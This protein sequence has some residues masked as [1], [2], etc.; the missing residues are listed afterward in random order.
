MIKA[1][2]DLEQSKILK[3]I[4][5]PESADTHYWKFGLKTY[6]LS[7]GHSREWQEGYE[8]KKMEYIPAWSLAALLSVLQHPR[9]FQGDTSSYWFCGCFAKDGCYHETEASNPIDACVEMICKL[10]EQKLL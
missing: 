4:L 8:A 5:P 3:E 9:C 2:T 7:V 10:H 6:H 1:Y